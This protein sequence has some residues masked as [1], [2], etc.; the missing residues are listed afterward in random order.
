MNLVNAPIARVWFSTAGRA[1][2]LLGERQAQESNVV[3]QSGEG[4]TSKSTSA[5]PP[6]TTLTTRE[7]EVIDLAAIGLSNKQIAE[8]LFLSE[9]TILGYMKSI[10]TKL[11]AHSKVQAVVLAIAEGIIEVPD[12]RIDQPE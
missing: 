9:H 5:V 4:A 12:I 1:G 6:G 10:F 11:G 8:Q 3:A 7:V 2:T